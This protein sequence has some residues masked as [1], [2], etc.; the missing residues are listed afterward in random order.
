MSDLFFDS[1]DF[2]L[3]DGVRVGSVMNW[4]GVEQFHPYGGCALTAAQLRIIA[5]KLDFLNGDIA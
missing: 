3:V 1:D 2:V 5:D 4:D